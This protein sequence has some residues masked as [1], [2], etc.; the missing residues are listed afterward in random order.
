MSIQTI[1][2]EVPDD[3]IAKYSNGKIIFEDIEYW[4]NIKTIEDAIDYCKENNIG[5]F[6]LNSLIHLSPTSFEYKIA[7]LQLIKIAI[8]NNEKEFA[9]SGV[10]Y[11]PIIRYC[12]DKRSHYIAT[13]AVDGKKLYLFDS[14]AC[15]GTYHGLLAFNSYYSVGDSFSA[16]GFLSYNS[17]EK[18]RHVAKYFYKLITDIQLGQQCNYEWLSFND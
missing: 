9:T 5:N 18:A 1:T 6:S 13:I 14:Y 7:C 4:K 12:G 16:Y 17:K 11:E 3:K 10:R 8:T 15:C 2:I